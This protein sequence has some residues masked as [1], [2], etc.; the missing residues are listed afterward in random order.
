MARRA[1]A[2]GRSYT[3][4]PTNLGQVG[5]RDAGG[6]ARFGKYRVQ[7]TFP[8]VLGFGE[9]LALTMPF[10][11]G[12]ATGPYRWPLRTAA[13]VS[14]AFIMF[15]S[16]I[17]GA[18]VGTVGCLSAITLFAAAWSV[19]KWRRDP[20]SLIGPAATLA[21]P[22]M[23]AALV[24]GIAFIGRLRAM[25]WGDG[26]EQYSTDARVT[27][28]HLGIPKILSHPQGYGIGMGGNALNY[29]PNGFLSI[30]NYYLDIALEYGVVGFVLYYGIF[31]AAIYYCVK[32][33]M[34]VKTEEREFWA[35]APMAISLV[36]FIMIKSSFSEQSNH[37]IVFMILGM[38]TALA[39]RAFAD[40]QE[41]LGQQ[42]VDLHASPGRPARREFQ[43]PMRFK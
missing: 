1:C 26:S 22:A 37:P 13:A 12:F 3:E 28:W 23:A 42:P 27:Q 31:I 38:V 4:I 11:L 36:V 16:I 32:A 6:G 25:V 41:S 20:G 19:L 2:V 18:R 21:F 10:V 9:Y 8:T 29:R 5:G 30:D 24:T 34:K 17:C 35:L 7:S 39:Y 33:K 14:A 40:G 15:I 43:V